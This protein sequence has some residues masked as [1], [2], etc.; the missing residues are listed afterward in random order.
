MTT[1]IIVPL[2][3]SAVAESA[4]PLAR[5]LEQQLGARVTLISVLDVPSSFGGY[6]RSPEARET[7][8]DAVPRQP[9]A[10]M[11]QSPY[12]NWTGWSGSE[13]S[14]KQ[15]EEVANETTEAEKYL[16]QI[17]TTFESDHVETIVRLGRP[18]ERILDAAESREDSIIVLASHGRSGIGRAV[19]G[20]VTARVVQ[21]ANRPV[22][23]VR[24]SEGSSGEGIYDE[25]RN[26]LIPVDGS[27]LSEQAIPVVAG[28]FKG[29]GS[30]V[31]LLNVIETPRFANSAQA[32]GYT[33]WLAE[34][35]TESGIAAS[36]EVT[37]GWP[38][39]QINRVAA[40]QDVELIAMST[41]G[42]TG[43]NRFALGSVAERVLHDADRPLMLA[44]MRT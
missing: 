8:F 42:R 41:H 24:A 6:V 20:S 43:L 19:V 32:E 31:H 16:Q 5:R 26:I 38:A 17:A 40:T 37:K 33:K 22:F 34:Q 15:I 25:I 11:P 10:A 36:W 44:P 23:V 12:G 28:M 35:V 21:A 13:P 14:A 1:R 9:S 2:D 4:L 29:E 30:R 18:A 39:D 7:P 27:T 3:H